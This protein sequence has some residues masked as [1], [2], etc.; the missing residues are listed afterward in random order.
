MRPPTTT[1]DPIPDSL[2]LPHPGSMNVK[3][4]EPRLLLGPGP[5][6]V[7]PRILE[8]MAAPTLG[9]LDPQFLALMDDVNARLREVFGTEN[10]MTFPVSG[11][12]SAAMEAS[13]ANLVEPGDRVIV[14]VN[15]VFGGRLAEMARRMGG[16]VVEVEAAWGRIIEP[17]QIAE[18]LAAHP[19]TKVVAVVLAETS[20]G[21]WQ[22]LDEI[23]A[24]VREQ[25]ALL[26]VDAVTALGGTPVDVDA[27]QIDVA[28]A[29][30][31]KCLGVP[32]GLGPIS[33]SERALAKVKARRAPV[34]SWYLDVGLLAGYLGSERRY[35]HTAPI[36]MMY[37]LH[38]GLVIVEEEGLEARFARH[39][40]VGARLAEALTE[41][42]FGMFA[43]E[44][45]RLPQL[46]A[47]S[48]PEGLDEAP[49]R[50][51]LLDEFGIEVGGGLGPAKGTLWRI[52]LMGHGASDD[53]V[54]RLIE[55]I[56]HLIT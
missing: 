22:P 20:T 12:G 35:H 54:D 16:E 41:R 45:H 6:P 47:A 10:Q 23:G 13:L 7:S 38:E 30:T 9:H 37:A 25:G 33:F 27:H 55:A 51:R 18:A 29:G 49:L 42:G 28:Y 32:P 48:L 36:N 15:G 8:A 11:T 53:N 31:Q 24:M 56:D 19:D 1:S 21:V 43:Q 3:D 40:R 44:G 26:V 17:G 4:L 14:G 39:R 5:S 50:R 34:Q 2:L 46:T 52:G